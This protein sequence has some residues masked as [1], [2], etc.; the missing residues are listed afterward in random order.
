MARSEQR[1]PSPPVVRRLNRVVLAAARRLGLGAGD[2]VVAGVS[3]GPDS[4]A[5]L[6]ALGN[7][8]GRLGFAA[9]PAHLIHDFRGQERYDDADFV[10]RNWPDSIIEEVDVA[11]YQRQYGVSSFEQAARDLRYDF[12]ARAARQVGSQVVALGHTADDLAET[13]LLH[14]AR[15]SGMHGLRGMS[16]TGAWPYP[17]TDFNLEIG[18]SPETGAEAAQWSGARVS[19]NPGDSGLQ[20]WR[21]LLALR[22]AD[23]IAYCGAR[24]V[25][26]RDDSTNYMREFAR[27]RVRLDL[28]PALAEQLNPQII[29]ALGRL[30]RIAAVQLEYLEGRA[31]AL[32]PEVAPEP[33]GLDGS[34]RLHRAGLAAAHPALR[35]LL[36][37]RAWRTVTGHEKRLTERHLTAMAGVITAP[38][39]GKA[40]HLP[41]G[42][43]LAA[44]GEWIRLYPAHHDAGGGDNDIDTDINIDGNGAGAYPRLGSAFRLTLPFGAIAI[45]VTKRDG[46]EV[47]CRAETLTDAGA[48]DTGDPLAA[49]LSPDALS[50]GAIV[51]A[52]QPGD[53]IRPLGMTGSRKLADLFREAGIPAA[54]RDRMP[55]VVTPQGIA[56][57]VGI[58]IAEW[59]AVRRPST[60]ALEGGAMPAVLV[61]FRPASP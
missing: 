40:V 46:W 61:S 56:W 11:E 36:L 6:L 59:A 38:G 57:A 50:D 25:D 30:A 24:G 17:E 23:T 28:M 33:A 12:L 51:R 45:G 10:R 32:W 43:I 22:R 54:L 52:A 58:R 35:P 14:I 34:L 3:G 26:Y 5:L 39:C 7:A 8:A 2:T 27:N 18:A 19:A 1:E 29:D 13:A 47:T 15:G 44:A 20:V 31:A 41:G 16:E 49:Y 21:P 4:C 9:R 48:L 60:G 42:H 37:R 53:R 55:L